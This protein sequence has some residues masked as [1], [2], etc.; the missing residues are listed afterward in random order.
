VL[1]DRALTMLTLPS[2]M[3]ALPGMGNSPEK[4]PE[5]IADAI[6]SFSIVAR[7]PPAE[8]AVIEIR[9]RAQAAIMAHDGSSAFDAMRRMF[10]ENLTGVLAEHGRV[11]AQL[12]A[13]YVILG[14]DDRAA[15]PEFAT[16]L[17]AHCQSS[18]SRNLEPSFRILNVERAAGVR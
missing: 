9:Y 7:R 16:D 1:Q 3:I 14:G 4:L 18:L 10:V 12:D 2:P 11:A 8:L 17:L 15:L 6:S 5:A 13:D